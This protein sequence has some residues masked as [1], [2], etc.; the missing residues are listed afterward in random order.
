MIAAL[1]ARHLSEP[2]RFRELV[3]ALYE[4]GVR[5][6]VQAGSGSLA[7]FVDDVLAGKPHHAMSLLA[8]RRSALDQLRRA[9]AALYVEGAAIDLARVGLAGGRKAARAS[10][11]IQLALGVPLIDIDLPPLATALRAPPHP[12]SVGGPLFEAFDATLRDVIAAQD[13]VL[14]AFA[15]KPQ[16]DTRQTAVT[17][18]AAPPAPA[19]AAASAAAARDTRT[20]RVAISA[21]AFPEILGHRLFPQPDHW[22]VLADRMPV[23][24]LTMSVSLMMEAAQ[25][26]DSTKIATGVEAVAAHTW[27][28][29]EPP[30][31]VTIT[32]TRLG[33][34]RI[35]VSID[36]YIECVVTMAD[37]YP[38][39]PELTVGAIGEA[40]V[41]PIMGDAI[42][43]DGWTFH[44]PS[45]RA[46]FPSMNSAAAACARSCGR[47]RRAARCSTPR[48]S[49]SAC[50]LA[51]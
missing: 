1:F 33:G 22:P 19:V 15:A 4:H 20:D 12:A 49:W 47:C 34:D 44:G 29:A 5:V 38:E 28:L 9:C 50:G 30:V 17:A 14:Q 40:K 23:V 25:R 7:A 31:E 21:A 11:A 18:S 39:P 37:H 3:L 6:F 46:S 48:A 32:A 43:R 13:A 51:R 42:Y 26:L 10:R 8:P 16:A 35:R 2:V 45:T 27:L 24:P 36:R 41:Y